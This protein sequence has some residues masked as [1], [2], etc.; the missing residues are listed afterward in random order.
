MGEHARCHGLGKT[1][2]KVQKE[3]RN[4][5]NPYY[6]KCLLGSLS[7][8]FGFPFRAFG[9]CLTFLVIPSPQFMHYPDQRGEGK[10]F[11]QV[12]ILLSS[13]ACLF[14]VLRRCTTSNQIA[15]TSIP[16]FSA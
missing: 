4:K 8:L 13:K 10:I 3:V 5:A 6:Y 1:V 15:H 11:L 2:K 9:S 12:G 14:I 7:A 16:N